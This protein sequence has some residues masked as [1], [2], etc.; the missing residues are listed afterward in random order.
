M[1]HKMPA[2]ILVSDWL[3]RITIIATAEI[4]MNCFLIQLGQG[5]IFV[6][7]QQM[8][9]DGWTI[10]KIEIGTEWAAFKLDLVSR[11]TLSL[12]Q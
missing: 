5:Q 3:I 6:T 9:N 12:F 7:V 10:F 1:L 2:Q 11:C 8:A 4:A